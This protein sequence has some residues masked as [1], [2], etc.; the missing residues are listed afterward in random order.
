[1][2]SGR[3]AVHMHHLVQLHPHLSHPLQLEVTLGHVLDLYWHFSE[4]G[5][6]YLGRVLAFLQPNSPSFA[7][8]PLHFKLDEPMSNAVIKEGMLLCF[9]PILQK[10]HGTLVDPTGLLLRFLAAMVWH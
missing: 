5:D 4:P 2:E 3:G 6:V 1:M 10:W 8:L 9:V 7:T